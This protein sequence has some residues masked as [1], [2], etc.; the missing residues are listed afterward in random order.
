MALLEAMLAGKAIVASRIS[1]IPEAVTNEVE[2]LLCLPGDMASL[3][4]ALGRLL[5]NP[6]LRSRLAEAALTR[7]R[8]D[9][10]VEAMVD[11]YEARYAAAVGAE[12][13]VR[14]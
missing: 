11:S 14:R 6:Q 8:R 3:A 5:S 13:S 10:T 1:G 9:F 2:G 7:A 12:R 4:K